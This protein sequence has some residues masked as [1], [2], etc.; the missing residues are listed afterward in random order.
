MTHLATNRRSPRRFL[1]VWSGRNRLTATLR[2]VTKRR[3]GEVYRVANHWC[4]RGDRDRRVTLE[5]KCPVRTGNDGGVRTGGLPPVHLHMLRH[6]CGFCLANRGYDL[7]L[8]QDYLGHRDPKHTV[9]YTRAPP[10]ASRAFGVESGRFHAEGDQTFT[11]LERWAFLTLLG[12][13]PKSTG[14]QI[15]QA[16][17]DQVRSS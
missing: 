12:Q 6:S 3:D 5:A 4:T 8:I 1:G 16:G 10:D 14:W 15:L 7:R 9:H 11:V 2:D 17:V 13:C